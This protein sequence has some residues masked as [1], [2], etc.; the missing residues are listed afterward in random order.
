MR[1]TKQRRD[2][3]VPAALLD[4]P[5]ARID[6][7]NREIRRRRAGGHV[8]RVLSMA[9]SVRDDES[10]ARGREIAIRY[11][12]GDALLPFGAQ[13]VGEVGEIDLSAARDVGGARERFE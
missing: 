7:H 3:S 2:V 11:I 12:D 9:R 4:N 10:P 8:A 6:Q 1:D 13:T 5:V